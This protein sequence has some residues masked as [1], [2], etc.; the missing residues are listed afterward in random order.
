[1]SSSTKA[2]RGIEEL[3]SGVV[4]EPDQIRFL[5]AQLGVTQSDLAHF[6]G[7][8]LPTVC[9]WETGLRGPGKMSVLL[10]T[11][12]SRA[13]SLVGKARAAELV[14][15]RGGSQAES[16]RDLLCAAFPRK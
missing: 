15:G 9:R 13:A 14:V 16:V 3:L 5:R 7:V 1:M 4:Q 12:A 10:M 8:A 2:A 6:L 11:A